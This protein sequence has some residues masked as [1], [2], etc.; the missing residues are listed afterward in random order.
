VLN[1]RDWKVPSGISIGSCKGHATLYIIYWVGIFCKYG[2][3]L[4]NLLLEIYCKYWR[5]YRFDLSLFVN[6]CF[7]IFR[8]L[9]RW[10]DCSV[11]WNENISRK[12]F[13]STGLEPGLA[14]SLLQDFLD[15]E[16]LGV[17]IE[18]DSVD[19][20]SS[21]GVAKKFSETEQIFFH[22][23]NKIFSLLKNYRQLLLII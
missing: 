6:M 2:D 15:S 5:T 20:G 11:I 8:N 19:P 3:T 14:C 13:G 1:Y 17:L 22:F 21:T 12:G 4:N 10:L 18:T 9:V 7:E 16:L 23:E